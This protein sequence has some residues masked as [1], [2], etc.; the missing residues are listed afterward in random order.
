VDAELDGIIDQKDRVVI[1]KVAPDF[2]YGFSTSAS[3]KGVDL[4]ISFQGSNGN[5]VY[6]RLRRTLETPNGSYNASTELL[7]G[8]TASNPSQTVPRVSLDVRSSYLDSRFVEDASYLR[9]K[10]I[11]LGYTLPINLRA[12]TSIALRLFVSAQ[13]LLTI[14]GYHGYD[15]EV[16]HG[17]DPGIYPRARTYSVGASI[18]F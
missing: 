7:N 3:Y 12:T 6:N 5:N 1:G 8:W 4:F 11:T 15:P 18:T 16:E 14:T 2:T 9:L 13:N 10:N 17:Y